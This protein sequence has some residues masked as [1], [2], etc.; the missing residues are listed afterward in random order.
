MD[1]KLDNILDNL[2][3]A[4]SPAV[5]KRRKQKDEELFQEIESGTLDN[6]LG[7]MSKYKKLIAVL[8]KTGRSSEVPHLKQK[9]DKLNKIV[10]LIRGQEQDQ[11]Y[12]HDLKIQKDNAQYIQKL[13]EELKTA[14]KELDKFFVSYGRDFELLKKQLEDRLTGLQ[15]QLSA[16][17]TQ[18]REVKEQILDIEIQIVAAKERKAIAEQKI[19]AAETALINLFDEECQQDD[20][21][22][23]QLD[24]Q[25]S[26][27]S[28]AHDINNPAKDSD[29]FLTA[30]ILQLKEQFE[31]K[32]AALLAK[33]EDLR[34]IDNEKT[35]INLLRAAFKA[36]E[37][38]IYERVAAHPDLM[39]VYTELK[40]LREDENIIKELNAREQQLKEKEKVLQE[41]VSTLA[42]EV[43]AVERKIEEVAPMIE[44]PELETAT[45]PTPFPTTLTP[46]THK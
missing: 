31:Q 2:K 17:L 13:N 36:Q 29:E 46:D 16:V 28:C 41:K 42:N 39:S 5:S 43:Q 10:K 23:T 6:V 1:K 14:K 45:S 11:L 38:R 35:R 21:L 40:E 22:I 34:Q 19:D 24:F 15:K 27:H 18:L 20:S 44:N 4:I 8:A 30:V 25:K 26:V 32:A 9:L 33:I 12:E 37:E 7:M 3:K